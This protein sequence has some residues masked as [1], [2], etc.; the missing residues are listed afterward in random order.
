MDRPWPRSVA[1][2]AALASRLARRYPY[3]GAD[4][5]W[6]GLGCAFWPAPATGV[7]APV[8]APGAP[9]ILVVATTGDPATPYA[10]GVALAHQLD[11]GVLLTHVGNGHTVYRVPGDSCVVATVDRYLLELLAPSRAT[12]ATCP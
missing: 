9:P 1:T 8:H 10:Q 3:F 2:Y 7:P 5:G 12:G 4:I 11:S 6:S